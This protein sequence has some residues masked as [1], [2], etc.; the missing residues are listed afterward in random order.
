MYYVPQMQQRYTGYDWGARTAR[1]LLDAVRMKRDHE[2]RQSQMKIQN[3]LLDMERKQREAN[4][5][6]AGEREKAATFGRRLSEWE[7]KKEKF[8][9]EESSGDWIPNWIRDKED[10]E[11]E[12]EKAN[13]AP[14]MKYE[15]LTPKFKDIGALPQQPYIPSMF[16]QDTA[17]LKTTRQIL[18]SL[19]ELNDLLKAIGANDE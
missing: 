13:P 5:L 8:A 4:L 19:P 14:E 18:Q 1:N 11:R 15:P 2:Y 7:D 10:Y 9:N 17:P 12:F 3:D 16:T 6:S